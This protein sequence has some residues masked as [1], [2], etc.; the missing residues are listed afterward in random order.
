MPLLPAFHQAEILGNGNQH[1][2]GKS[3]SIKPINDYFKNILLSKEK[4]WERISYNEHFQPRIYE[5]LGKKEFH[6]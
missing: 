5:I 3:I 2:P 6:C 1:K 4:S